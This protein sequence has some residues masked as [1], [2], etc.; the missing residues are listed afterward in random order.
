MK[1][2]GK[3]LRCA[4]VRPCIAKKLLSFLAWVTVGSLPDIA[5]MNER[6]KTI[7]KGDFT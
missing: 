7:E 5:R 6:G 4:K 1:S 2:E 3:S